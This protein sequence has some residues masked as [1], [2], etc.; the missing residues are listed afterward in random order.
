MNGLISGEPEPCAA[1]SRRRR[2]LIVALAAIALLATALT[3]AD[4]S[5]TQPVEPRPA[6]VH[7]A[8]RAVK[9]AE[10]GTTDGLDVPFTLA[11][12]PDAESWLRKAA[13]AASREEWKVAVDAL[14]RV[15][16]QHTE[17]FVSLDEMTVTT[18]LDAAWA[19]LDRWPP[20]GRET[21]RT[22]FEPEA[23]RLLSEARERSDLDAL[24]TIGRKY[25]A[26][27]SGAAALNLLATLT[28]DGGRPHEA[29]AALRQLLARRTGP[30]AETDRRS[31]QL[32][33]AVAEALVG[34]AERAEELLAVLGKTSPPPGG[35]ARAEADGPPSEQVAAVRRFVQ[36]YAA[37][38]GSESRVR[39]AGATGRWTGL[40]GGGDCRG[41]APLVE[42]SLDFP[43]PWSLDLPGAE[44]ISLPQFVSASTRFGLAP[45][46]QMATD[47]RLLFVRT[48]T[49]I[50]ALDGATF[51]VAWEAP[52]LSRETPLVRGR[53]R[54][55][56]IAVDTD[57][58]SAQ[59][60]ALGPTGRRALFNDLSGIVGVAGG[61]VFVIEEPQEVVMGSA[62]F[63]QLGGRQLGVL[64]SVTDQP[65]ENTLYA[66]D[67][68]SGKL[69]WAHGAGGPLG[70]GLAGA[71]FLSTP[72]ECGDLLAV[73]FV[74]DTDFALALLR[75]DGTLVRKIVLG[76][77]PPQSFPAR[78][79]LPLTTAGDLL[80]VPTGA[81]MVLAL[82]RDDFS[83]R[84][85][86]L[87][88]SGPTIRT[89]GG[90]LL[91]RQGLVRQGFQVRGW[92]S[93]PPVVA[94]GLVLLAPPDS[95]ALLAFDRQTGEKRWDAA[96]DEH[97]YI[98]A[99]DDRHV[100]VVGTK[101]RAVRLSDG[102]R[103][104][105]W[106]GQ[107]I[108]ARPILSGNRLY[109]PTAER[110]VVLDP[111]TGAERT[112]TSRTAR[113]D[114]RGPLNG[115]RAFGNLLAWDGSLYHLTAT[116]LERIP[117]L[118]RSIE[119]AERRLRDDPADEGA[120]LRLAVLESIRGQP[121]RVL[122]LLA[123]LVRGTTPVNAGRPAPQAGESAGPELPAD[124]A[125]RLREQAAHLW[126]E[127]NL[128]LAAMA[129]GPRRRE[130]LT[131]ARD[132]A[133]RPGDRLRVELA[134]V[135]SAAAD[136]D[137]SRAFGRLLK[138]LISV[139]GEIVPLGPDAASS[140]AGA[141]LYG[142]AWIS[143]S[144]RMERLWNEMEDADRRRAAQ[145]MAA[146]LGAVDSDRLR[147]RLSDALGFLP[148]GGV[149]DLELGR[150]RI[151]S[152]DLESAE[153]HLQRCVRRVGPTGGSERSEEQPRIA[154]AAL[155]AL[156]R[157]HLS[158]G[159][160]LAPR[161]DLA[162]EALR[163]LNER[164]AGLPFDLD[165]GEPSVP[166]PDMRRP[167]PAHPDPA[168]TGER[169]SR[170]VGDFVR[171][172][173]ALLPGGGP[174]AY[175]ALQRASTDYTRWELLEQRTNSS[176]AYAH[177]LRDAALIPP[178]TGE[179]ALLF[180]SRQIL[181]LDARG[182]GGRPSAWAVDAD[183]TP[184]VRALSREDADA[185]RRGEGP[186]IGAACDGVAAVPAESVY[187]FL[188]VSTGR[189]V[190]PP[191]AV[192]PGSGAL[193]GAGASTGI[194]GIE[195]YFVAAIDDQTLVAVPA[196]QCGGA[197]WTR[198]LSDTRIDRLA[199]ADGYAVVLSADG[200]QAIVIRPATGRIQSRIDLAVRTAAAP[201]R[202]RR[203]RASVDTAA[204][205][206]QA[207]GAEAPAGANEESR[208]SAD[209]YAPL[210]PR[211]SSPGTRPVIVGS[212]ICRGEGRRVAA[213][214]AGSG[215]LM[216][217]LDL[218]S[219]AT[220]GGPDVTA[221]LPLSDRLLGVTL[222]EDRYAVVDVLRGERLF[223]LTPVDLS[224]PP[225][226]AAADA[227]QVILFSRHAEE[228]QRQRLVAYDAADGRELW[229][230]SG[231]MFAT[232]TDEMLRASP[233]AIPVLLN[234][235]A[236]PDGRMPAD[237]LEGSGVL[238]RLLLVDRRT[239]GAL[240]PPLVIPRPQ[241]AFGLTVRDVL[242]FP[243]RIIV[244][245][246]QGYFV[247]GAPDAPDDPVPSPRRHDG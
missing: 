14:W 214:H 198:R 229:S 141:G 85:A 152:G 36:A 235:G 186:P 193:A 90:V 47:G 196:R 136:D 191:L 221:L 122:T 81:G 91:R 99:A 114:E 149:L 1:A 169:G 35:A 203:A 150:R 17:S 175:E 245:I 59:A 174:A 217:R 126:V 25:F 109:V 187:Y 79:A 78:I 123:D 182:S 243:R 31:L 159:P 80:L 116:R 155:A 211:T 21:Y 142:P 37:G 236:Q 125:A 219:A 49:G 12:D 222:G 130:L 213:W 124:S 160:D 46:W 86:G 96:R 190:C 5:A 121:E 6:P 27:P 93:N 74:I 15:V 77:A 60:D 75:P 76:S 48:P 42:P 204:A 11:R 223:E 24:R 135:E 68:G 237:D 65:V 97:R 51:D 106:S 16:D 240:R 246:A 138:L 162:A 110:L 206:R 29:A 145:E 183:D 53:T 18:A 228:A 230:R 147:L 185:V 58:D 157:L 220:Q 180:Y 9:I 100:Y 247:Y 32:R 232:L 171:S 56:S 168:G 112:R 108:T 227:D 139:G 231:L 170:T 62:V 98:A 33:L 158:P 40:L 134:L 8:M 120:A 178:P 30:P 205:P 83:L 234:V 164:Y 28:L 189:L 172:A 113:V 210:P 69:L 101:I 177:A 43:T 165:A 107:P 244:V 55:L 73:S 102:R 22:L 226:A 199:K 194:V 54:G 242:M 132:A 13:A 118:P 3:A 89:T 241:S 82:G 10:P 154:A 104:W 184:L 218:S 148:A 238:A 151:D 64:E 41:A 127:A 67:A 215:R 133:R 119:R 179:S 23:A 239:G 209:L 208:A 137:G 144:E 173:A 128:D 63:R 188:G 195:G 161:P 129:D 212:F 111:R 117:D 52:T 156:V 87:Y 140:G 94:G 181:A 66:F 202:G 2:G 233:H 72:V 19:M 39:V 201:D 45:V 50:T 225:L 143:I 153:F 103:A 71:H 115:S 224:L 38:A 88:R 4:E 7:A 166:T 20:E 146:A 44:D 200:R 207:P 216:W 176:G 34:G 84:W 92:A 61:R 70:G 131:A 192:A 57:Q 163:S 26:V 167:R 95:E 197:Q 105:L